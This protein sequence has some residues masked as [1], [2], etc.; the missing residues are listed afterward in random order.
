MQ[1]REHTTEESNSYSLFLYA[2]RSPVTR[3]YY[4][5]RLRSFFNHIDPLDKG[6]LEEKCNQFA[7]AG[8]EIRIGLFIVYYGFYDFR[9]KG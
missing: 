6:S 4:L 1:I 5:R 3:D 2:I 8:A 9:G 7:A